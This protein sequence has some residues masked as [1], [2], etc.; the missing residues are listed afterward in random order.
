MVETATHTV[1]L[2]VPDDARD[3]LAKV[4]ADLREFEAQAAL[5]SESARLSVARTRERLEALDAALSK[6]KMLATAF[7]MLAE[8]LTLLTAKATA[9]PAQNGAAAQPFL[10]LVEQL[11]NAAR[12]CAMA[13]RHLETQVR[14]SASTA[15]S[16]ADITEKSQAVLDRFAPALRTLADA[17]ARSA[18]TRAAATTAAT[19]VVVDG[20]STE[21]EPRTKGEADIWTALLRPA[22]GLKN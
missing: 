19:I 1:E 6:L 13:V 17:A 22:V 14:S 18:S 10:A 11:I 21:P 8:R 5:V 15:E 20:G 16:I 4:S 7:D 2:P 12:T 3:R 9:E